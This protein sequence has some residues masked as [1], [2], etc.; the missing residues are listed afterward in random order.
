MGS[1]NFCA[2]LSA[3][4]LF[5]GCRAKNVETGE[6]LS[7]SKPAYAM[8]IHG[9]AGTI[10][11][12]NMTEAQEMQYR[13]VLDSVLQLGESVL[14]NGGSA[15]EAVIQSVVLMENSPLFNA[16][17]GSVFSYDGKNEMD[18]SVMDGRN[19]AAG[20]VA[21]VSTIKNPIL[22]AR[23]VMEKSNHVM[24]VGSGAEQFAKERGLEMAPTEYFKTERRWEALQ[25]A[26]R[27]DKNKRGELIDQKHGTVGA[28]ALDQFGN[29]AAATS[30]G[31]MTNKRWN[32]VGDSP[33]IG[34]GTY[35]DNASCA[36]SC[37]G[38]GEYFIRYAVAHDIAAMIEYKQINAV[39]AG[40]KVINKK[41]LDAGGKG[42]AI[43]LDRNG[44]IAM[45]FN[46]PGMYRGFVTPKERKVFIFK[47]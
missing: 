29:L 1:V 17:R 41:L 43:I 7:K 4:F 8:V 24:L 30:T 13:S 10:K 23:A 35:A 16:G 42:G 33:I 18:A 26:K 31:G 32:R 28:V 37:T 5:W 40:E 44:H 11:R 12:E 39:E 46:T 6:A 19:K 36:V 3:L 38:H 45:P 22:A 21:G 47:D 34:A 9:G 15:M 14:R 2:L 27:E 25:R 20:A